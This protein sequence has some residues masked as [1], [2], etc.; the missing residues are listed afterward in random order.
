[1]SVLL[2]AA[3]YMQKITN[4]V[5]ATICDNIENFDNSEGFS[6]INATP[7]IDRIFA[8]LSPPQAL[9]FSLTCNQ[10]K[11][12]LPDY[13]VFLA[14]TWEISYK[15]YD[16]L[17]EKLKERFLEFKEHWSQSYRFFASEKP[18][19]QSELTSFYLRTKPQT[20]SEWSSF[21]TSCVW[22]GRF[23]SKKK[24]QDFISFI[25]RLYNPNK[26]PPYPFLP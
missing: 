5:E 21:A 22:Y 1:M 4:S 23:I 9:N 25:K 15:S 24:D 12:Y 17:L 8:F 2:S 26:T 10:I 7:A 16:E 13:F 19:T 3:H 11:R 14:D 6:I 18:R 20:A